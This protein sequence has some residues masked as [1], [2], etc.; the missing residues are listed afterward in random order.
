M[1]YLFRTVEGRAL[2]QKNT[3]VLGTGPG[4]FSV[5]PAA[6]QLCESP[7]CIQAGQAAIE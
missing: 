2:S 5:T 4:D 6:L 3:Q 1:N 7:Y